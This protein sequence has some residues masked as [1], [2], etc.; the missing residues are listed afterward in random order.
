MANQHGR[1]MEGERHT[2]KYPRD[3]PALPSGLQPLPFYPNLKRELRSVTGA[4]VLTYLEIYHPPSR[5]ASG[6]LLRAPVTLHLD[7]ISEDLQISRRTLFTALC[8]LAAR[9]G[10]EE[11]RARAARA[12]R[13]FLNPAHTV[14]GRFKLYSVTGAIGYI[15]HTIV[16]LS[17]NFPLISAMLQKAG[18][19]SLTQQ[20]VIGIDR[21]KTLAAAAL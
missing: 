12:G 17:R 16:Q 2:P 19:T 11:A 10:S 13:E 4:L 21:F 20:E 14:N 6:A 1:P 5:D 8:V 3:Y 18:I 9:W 7:Q 15:P